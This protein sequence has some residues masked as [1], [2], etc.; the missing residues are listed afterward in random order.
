MLRAFQRNARQFLEQ[1]EKPEVDYIEGLSPSIAI[2]QK[3]VSRSPR[4][5]VGT[6]TEIYDYMRV[7]FTRIGIPYCYNCGSLITTQDINNIIRS[8][9]SLPPG[10]K[11]QILAPIVRDRKGEYKKELQQ[12]RVERLCKSQDD[13]KMA[14]L[15][16]NI[17][18]KKQKRP[19]DRD[20]Y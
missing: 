7:L 18:L 8:I 6:I 3:T 1:M 11:M 16:G 10:T 12:M 17:S 15:T 5:T 4:S 13:G 2:N 14:D 9:L 20:R 19:Y